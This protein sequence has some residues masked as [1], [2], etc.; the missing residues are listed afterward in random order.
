MLHRLAYFVVG[1]FYGFCGFLCEFF[2]HFRCYL[3]QEGCRLRHQNPYDSRSRSHVRLSLIGR[4]DRCRLIAALLYLGFS[5]L[6]PHFTTTLLLYLGRP[7]RSA[8]GGCGLISRCNLWYG[9]NRKLFL[10]LVRRRACL[11]AV[12]WEEKAYPQLCA[13]YSITSLFE[14]HA[15]IWGA[16]R[17]QFAGVGLFGPPAVVLD[18]ANGAYDLPFFFF[19]LFL[20]CTPLVKR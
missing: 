2:N 15:C 20:F 17:C 19:F 4:K 18:A 1:D 12:P 13:D 3:T 16:W 5:K 9:G 11:R 10:V 8:E 6:P 7:T 14:R